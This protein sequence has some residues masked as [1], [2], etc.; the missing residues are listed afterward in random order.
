MRAVVYLIIGGLAS[1]ALVSC[2][3]SVGSGTATNSFERDL[4]L[5]EP[6][7]EVRH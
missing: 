2:A 3:I 4:E 1:V 6:V 7:L 5:S